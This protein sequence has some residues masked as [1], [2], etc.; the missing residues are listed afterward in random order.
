MDY[1]QAALIYNRSTERN[2]AIGSYL[3]AGFWK[4]ALELAY[5]LNYESV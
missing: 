5:K 4:E 2:K 1:K 3:K